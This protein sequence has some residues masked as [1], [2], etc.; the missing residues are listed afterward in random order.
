MRLIDE[1]QGGEKAGE[2]AAQ[3]SAAHALAERCLNAALASSSE[4]SATFQ[5][6]WINPDGEMRPERADGFFEIDEE[7][8]D[9]VE[10]YVTEV[11]R[12]H[13]SLPGSIVLVETMVYPLHDQLD[14]FG[15]GDA[16]IV[17]P[18]GSLVVIDF[19]YGAGVVVEPQWNDQMM[20]YGLGAVVE[21]A[22]DLSIGDVSLVIVQ[23]R[24][25]HAVGPIR[26]W[27][28]DLRTLRQFE[29][30]LRSAAD[31][32]KAPDAP[33]IPGPH[34]K[35]TFC[36]VR[37][38][39]PALR[40][41]AL[42]EALK[43]FDL[44]GV[45]PSLRLPDL[46]NAAELRRAMDLRDLVKTWCEEIPRLIA[47][48]LAMGKVTPEQVG[49]KFVE[50]RTMRRWKSDS[51]IVEALTADGIPDEQI[52][53]PQK[54]KSPAQIEK[55]MGAAWTSQYAEKPKGQPSLAPITDKR[56][57]LPI[58]PGAEFPDSGGE[59]DGL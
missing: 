33:L 2:H 34:C 45:Q 21:V 50:G 41:T 37:Y 52:Y 53:A 20:F 9:G 40:A 24:A 29:S 18:C 57:A 25:F 19:K 8:V 51:S 27:K 38:S 14:V 30:T 1:L 12:I 23:P 7:M 15:T 13:Q 36:P 5:G 10:M 32:T 22:D 16:I 28:T 42:T 55:I 4:R 54:V 17:Q 31:A 46:T 59:F 58:G 26:E 35:K 49:W 6:Q 39:C 11:M 43:D 48:A 44:P 47:A 56:P 3:G